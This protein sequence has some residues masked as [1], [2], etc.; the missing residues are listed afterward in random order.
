MTLVEFGDYSISPD[1]LTGES[2]VYSFGIGRDITFDEGIHKLS[3]CMVH[4]FDPTPIW[5]ERWS[6]RTPEWLIFHPYGLFKTDGSM[7]FY[8]PRHPEQVQSGCIFKEWF[9]GDN[10]I[11][12]PMK[13]LPTIMRELGHDHIDLL[14]MDV[15]GA[16]Y[17][18]IDGLES[19]PLRI[20]QIAL[21]FHH[22]LL[23]NDKPTKRAIAQ[24]ESLGYTAF[25]SPDIIMGAASTLVS[26]IH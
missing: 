21:E 11:Q 18:V 22:Y 1:G 19:N 12:V 4:G 25:I 5:I 7:E 20:G 6:Q 23:A 8:P 16:E 26:F 2:I 17:E 3:G 13:C 15:D 9:T 10:P 24:L 14:K